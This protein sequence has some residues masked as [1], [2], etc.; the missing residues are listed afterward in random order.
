MKIKSAFLASAP[1]DREVGGG[2]GGETNI[3]EVRQLAFPSM[4]KYLIIFIVKKT[5]DTAPGSIEDLQN[6]NAGGDGGNA[7]ADEVR[8]KNQTKIKYANS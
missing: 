5:Q 8:K 1:E 4:Q 6:N 7:P 3:Q 2:G